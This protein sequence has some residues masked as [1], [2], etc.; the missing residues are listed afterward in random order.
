MKK[1][2][3]NKSYRSLNHSKF[4]LTYHILFVCKYREK[5]LIKYGENIKQIMIDISKKYD[6]TIKEMEVDK[7]HIHLM[8]ESVPKVSPLMIIRVLK[9][10]ATISIWRIYKK[11]LRKH[12]WKENTFWTDGYFI[13]TIGEVSCKTL[14][15]YILNQG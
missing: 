7:D 8:I 6:V 10:Q 15:H 3:S 13:S 12:Y 5:L 4:I 2:K 14:K 9:Q 11:E 1:N